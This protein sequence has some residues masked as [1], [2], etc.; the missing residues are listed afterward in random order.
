MVLA[1]RCWCAVTG[2]TWVVGSAGWF[3]ARACL[4]EMMSSVNEGDE[5]RAAAFDHSHV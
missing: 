3:A 2:E 5:K 4:P 1:A